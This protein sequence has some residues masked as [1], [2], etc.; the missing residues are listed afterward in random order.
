MIGRRESEKNFHPASK[1]RNPIQKGTQNELLH[2]PTSFIK[3]HFQN[4]RKLIQF[5]ELQVFQAKQKTL[6][7]KQTNCYC[8]AS[9]R[10]HT[11]QE[12]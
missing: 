8:L 9:F 12:I 1:C 4:I 11:I 7:G 5:H 3:H 6:T 2:F 10:S